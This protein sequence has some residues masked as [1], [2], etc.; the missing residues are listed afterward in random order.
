MSVCRQEAGRPVPT[1]AKSGRQEEANLQ[2]SFKQHL[3][4]HSL[5]EIVGSNV[6]DEPDNLAWSCQMR[7][8]RCVALVQTA[9]LTGPIPT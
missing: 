1:L 6:G 3:Q 2:A 9:V 5:M 7:A 8:W 4:I